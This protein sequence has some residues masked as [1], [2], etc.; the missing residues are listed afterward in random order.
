MLNQN[1]GC[2][3]GQDIVS[4]KI[5]NS[6]SMFLAP[7]TEDEV[8][9]VTSELKSKFSAGY[10]DIPEK[11]VKES[12][13]RFIKKTTNISLCSGTFPNLMKIAKVRPIYKK[14]VKQEIS[15]YRPISVL[16]VFLKILE[17]LINK[18]VVQKW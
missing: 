4:K 12:T 8:L 10:D 6:N 2:K 18:R 16:T 15:S 17:I 9:N 3:F 5:L 14:G 1:K 7:V 11:L 13:I